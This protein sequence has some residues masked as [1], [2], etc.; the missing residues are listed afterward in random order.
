MV[1]SPQRNLTI[2]EKHM[3]NFLKLITLAS[4][5][6]LGSAAIAQDAQAPKPQDDAAATATDTAADTATAETVADTTDTTEQTP[7]TDDQAQ[8]GETTG[9]T[10][11]ELSMG[12]EVVDE[13]APGT[14]YIADR[15]NDWELRCVRVEEGQKEPCQLFQLMKDEQGVAIAEMNLVTLANGGQAVAGA[16]IV[17]PLETL[18]TKQLTMSVDGGAKKRYPFRFCSNIGCYSQIGFSNGDIAS[19]KRGA[20]ASLTIVPAF[21]PD[22]KITVTLSLDGFTKAYGALKEISK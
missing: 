21:A 9:E 4:F 1:L 14:T 15:F 17:V 20:K 3:P 18:L 5:V 19:F 13:N 12:E 7:A 11:A 2:M 6:S 16:T 10:P 22:K 8:A